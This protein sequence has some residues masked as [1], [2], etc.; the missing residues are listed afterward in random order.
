MNEGGDPKRKEDLIVPP[1][2]NNR[3]WKTG[4]WVG[5]IVLIGFVVAVL[6]SDRNLTEWLF[7]RNTVTLVACCVSAAVL[8]LMGVIV[9]ISKW[10]KSER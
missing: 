9:A 10:R 8:V 5:L 3:A 7:S 6:L 1:L 2:Q 4:K